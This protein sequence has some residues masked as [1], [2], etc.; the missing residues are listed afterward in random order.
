MIDADEKG[1]NASEHFKAVGFTSMHLLKR[2]NKFDP[3]D[4]GEYG[5]VD[6]AMVEE[7]SEE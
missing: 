1:F 5:I 4:L 6:L 7:I 2:K 3:L